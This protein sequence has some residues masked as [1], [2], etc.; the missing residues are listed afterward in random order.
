MLHDIGRIALI[1]SNPQKYADLLA[2]LS[3]QGAQ[4]ASNLNGS[5]TLSE[6]EQKTYGIDKCEAGVELVRK[7]KLPP[8][9]ERVIS[10]KQE[11]DPALSV[12]DCPALI[13]LSCELAD[14]LGLGLLPQTEGLDWKA[15]CDRLLSSMPEAD[16]N[17][18]KCDW[19]N[20]QLTV[21][22]RVNLL[23]SEAAK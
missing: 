7:W 22:S 14:A 17:R 5:P 12:F 8:L 11:S 13:A 16:R 4:G 9:F 23:D 20:L 3:S 1:A 6:L 2:T 19:D 15:E 18:L 21:A 10:R